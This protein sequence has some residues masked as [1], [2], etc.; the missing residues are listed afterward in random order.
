MKC[1]LVT[2]S[3]LTKACHVL[4]QHHILW[5]HYE[6]LRGSEH[7]SQISYDCQV[8]DEDVEQFLRDHHLHV[9]GCGHYQQ[10]SR[11][12]P[13]VHRTHCRLLL[14]IPHLR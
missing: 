5:H 9:P 4:L 7:L 12:E 14:R 10:H 8:R 2:V 13:L 1:S 3:V 6:E 11:V